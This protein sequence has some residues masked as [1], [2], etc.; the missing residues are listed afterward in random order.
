MLIPV[1]PATAD[2][3]NTSDEDLDGY[4]FLD[5]AE[6]AHRHDGRSLVH[7]IT[8]HQ[9]WAED[10]LDNGSRILF[11][12]SFD[13]DHQAEREIRV[14]V[15]NGELSA[16]MYSGAGRRLREVKLTRPNQRSVRVRFPRR[17]LEPGIDRYVWRA[18]TIAHG[19]DDPN[20]EINPVAASM[21]CFDYAPN[22]RQQIT[23]HL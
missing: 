23:H 15:E 21:R 2:S 12:C 20:T 19:C 22:D 13:G 3:F 9:G 1:S 14:D 18:K 8:T 7:R 17:L 6:V 16:V 4:M 10:D 5:I 11:K